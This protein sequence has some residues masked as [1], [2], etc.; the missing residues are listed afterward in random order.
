MKHKEGKGP[1][2]TVWE[3]PDEGGH[4][5]RGKTVWLWIHPGHVKTVA[6]HPANQGDIQKIQERQEKGCSTLASLSTTQG[7]LQDTPSKNDSAEE[8]EYELCSLNNRDQSLH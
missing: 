8:W 5:N 6:H 4:L 2:I 3:W 1:C 7:G